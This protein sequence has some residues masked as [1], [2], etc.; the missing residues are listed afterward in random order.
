MTVTL[1]LLSDGVY[2]V[3]WK[4][5]ST[6][7]GH[8]TVGTFPFAVGDANAAAVSAVQQTSTARLPVSA[9]VAKFLLLVS[10]AIL[11]GQ[12]LFIALVWDLA[13]KSNQNDINKPAVWSVLYRIGLTGVLLSIGLGI[14]S[15]AGQATGN[16]LSYP[17]NFHTGHILTGTRLGVI[18]L[19]RLTLGMLAVWLAGRKESPLRDWT[20]FGVNLSL[21]LTVTL[22]SHAATEARPLLPILG[23]WIH[24]IGMT[25]WLGGLVYLFTGIRQIQQLEGQARTKLTSLLTSRF[26][27]NAIIF[28]SLIGI[29]GFYSAYLRVGTWPALLT[30]LYGHVLLVKQIFVAGLLVI[31]ATNLLVISP[32]LNRDRLQGISDTGLVARLGKILILDLTF[33]GLLLA[34]VSFFTYIPPAKAVYPQYRSY[35]HCKS[36][37][38]QAGYKHLTW[39]SWSKHVY[40]SPGFQWAACEICQKSFIA[41]HASPGKYPTL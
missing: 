36:G 15:Q 22:T 3:T 13:L 9:L 23:D 18:W 28:V 5:L 4:A 16:E 29:T 38:S 8:Q 33:A 10:L 19:A 32:R 39:A 37:R 7:D 21:L 34:S 12:R 14:L 26:S 2:T 25:F 24:L 41:L 20:G 6:V 11:V 30:S 1:H 35:K 31:A 40:T 27:I 17:W